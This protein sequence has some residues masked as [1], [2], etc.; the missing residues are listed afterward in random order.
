MY[1]EVVWE[2][3]NDAV[4]QVLLRNLVSAVHHLHPPRQGQRHRGPRRDLRRGE[5]L[6]STAFVFFLTH[7]SQITQQRTGLHD[8]LIP[9]RGGE[10]LCPS[11][12][13]P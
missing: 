5:S 9:R 3:L 4:H 2:H 13:G 1:V 6:Q 10:G 11:T 8:P 12:A 7:V